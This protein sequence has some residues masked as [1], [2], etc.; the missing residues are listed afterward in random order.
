MH[1]WLSSNLRLGQSLGNG[2]GAHLDTLAPHIWGCS[3]A[4][5][6]TKVKS[7]RRSLLRDA[8][9]EIADKTQKM[10]VGLGWTV[11]HTKSGMVLVSRPKALPLLDLLDEASASS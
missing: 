7:N 5:E 1:C 2:S 11:D 3:W 6:S 9:T 10:D 8:L 4:G